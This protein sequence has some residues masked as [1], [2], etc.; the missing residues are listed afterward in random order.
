MVG[1]RMGGAG[2]CA[3]R[4]GSGKGSGGALVFRTS[5][6]GRGD[7]AWLDSRPLGYLGGCAGFAG[8]GDGALRGLVVSIFRGIGWTS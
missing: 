5:L 4:C 7:R 8:G 1:R 3:S 2:R 6:I